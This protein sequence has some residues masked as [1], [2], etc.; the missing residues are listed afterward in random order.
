MLVTQPFP[1][2]S[3]PCDQLRAAFTASEDGDVHR[4]FSSFLFFPPFFSLSIPTFGS[5]GSRP[6]THQVLGSAAKRMAPRWGKEK[7]AGMPSPVIQWPRIDLPLLQP[8]PGTAGLHQ[9]ILLH[10]EVNQSHV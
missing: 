2:A 5:G 4:F 6:L 3:L 10:A 9:L 7:A 1:A 8:S